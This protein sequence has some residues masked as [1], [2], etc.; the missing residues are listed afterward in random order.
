[1]T[2]P[3]LTAEQGVLIAFLF[4]R[5]SAIVITMPLIGNRSVPVRVKAGVSLLIALLLF[6]SIGY[7][8]PY[9]TFSFFIG[10]LGEVFIGIVIGFIGQIIFAG[11][12][13][14][15]Q[16]IGFQ[17]G[18]AIVNVVDPVTSAQVSIIAQLQYLFALLIF[19]AFDGHHVFLM[20]IVES[21]RCIPPLGFS[22]SAALVNYIVT[23]S[24]DVFSV[25]A[26]IGAPVIALLLLISVGL[27]II[28]RTVPQINVFIVGFPLKIAVGLIAFG[29]VFP[30]FARNVWILFTR[31]DGS[32]GTL[33]KLM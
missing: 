33:L 1:M 29:I 10:C 16:L 8:G 25:A 9:D 28:A 20:A 2:V 3:G 23:L 26:T 17:M 14:A 5:I 21:Y 18:F 7:D 11:I 24:K 12:Q 22:N 13:L 6:P 27:G 32:V 4:L 19:L 15:G 31:L 30:F